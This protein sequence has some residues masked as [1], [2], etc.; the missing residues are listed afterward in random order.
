VAVGSSATHEAVS[1]RSHHRRCR[2]AASF[3]DPY[4]T[5]APPDPRPARIADRLVVCISSDFGRTPEYNDDGGKDHWP[6]GSAIFMKRGA[7]WADR[8]V[9]ATDAGHNALAIDP[10]TLAP[11]GNGGIVLRPKH[12]QAAYRALAGV[13]AHALSQRFPLDAE[14]I[15][16][17]DP[18]LPA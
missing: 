14:P 15:D 18:S 17:F 16:L 9:G 6:I 10:Q 12:V 8:V 13:E 1:P 5:S 3:N 11:V 4:P 2:G 7:P